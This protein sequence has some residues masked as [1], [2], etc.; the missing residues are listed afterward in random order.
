MLQRFGAVAVPRVTRV[1]R[2]ARLLVAAVAAAATDAV[3]LI[4]GSWWDRAAWLITAPGW[5]RFCCWQPA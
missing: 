3:M 4:A 2:Q 5:L 1:I